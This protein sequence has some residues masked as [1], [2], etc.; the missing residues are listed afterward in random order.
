MYVSMQNMSSGA[1]GGEILALILSRQAATRPDIERVSGLSRA[2]VAHRLQELLEI[3]L[4]DETAERQPSGGRPARILKL[5]ESFAV[6]LAADIGESVIRVAVTDLAP[7]ILAEQTVAIDVASGPQPILSEIARLAR[8][9]LKRV[10]RKPAHVLGIGLSL[11]APID[12]EGGRVV[13]PS[14]MRAWDNFDI[15]GW[16]EKALGVNALIDNDVNLLA[17]SE[18][19]RFWPAADHFF[20]VKAGTGIGSGIVVRGQVYRGGR[21]ASGDIGHIQFDAPKAPLCRCGKLGCVEAR[22]AGWAIARDLRALGF[23]GQDARDVMAL[24]DRGTPECIQRVREAGRVLGEVLADVVSILNPTTIVVG[25]TL[26]QAG[27]HLIAGI[28]EMIYQRCLPLA[29]EGLVIH[30]ARS[31]DRA[32]ILGAAQLVIDAKLQPAAIADTV[33]RVVG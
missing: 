23:E 18:H 14:V 8:A 11:P 19:R 32:G 20:F 17:L 13:G 15:R 27:E 26:A 22:A 21:G 9:L 5:N 10:G 28:R 16:L 4:I 6:T 12:H 31:D 1:G 29:I 30:T 33:A 24:L 7:R 3:G 2:T 25:G